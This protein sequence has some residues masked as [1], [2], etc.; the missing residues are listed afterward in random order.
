MA[1]PRCINCRRSIADGVHPYTI[2]VEMFPRVEESIKISPEEME[3][4]CDAEIQRLVDR[5]E[6][7]SEAE[8][9]EE[10][11]RVY[12]SFSY[13]ICPACRDLLTAQLKR[14]GP[15]LGV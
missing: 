3:V 5:L 9:I 8:R 4:D 10:E 1:A 15:T 13:T 6:S 2:R 11:E 12:V 14:G 7:M